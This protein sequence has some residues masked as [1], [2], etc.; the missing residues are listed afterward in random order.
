MGPD[1]APLPRQATGPDVASVPFS[2]SPGGVAS[3]TG[4]LARPGIPGTEVFEDSLFRHL[5]PTAERQEGQRLRGS[6]AGDFAKANRNISESQAR[7]GVQSQPS[8][9]MSLAHAGAQQ[10]AAQD[11]SKSF[12]GA[13][14]QA[15]QKG[16]EAALT[17]R[18]QS[19]GWLGQVV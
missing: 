4:G 3:N 2:G 5:S 19:L 14:S 1:S 10:R 15:V 9:L 17:G 8:N 16:I 13:R 12:S 11:V 6:I 18:G 7:R